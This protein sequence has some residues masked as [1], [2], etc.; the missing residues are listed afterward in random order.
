MLRHPRLA[1]AN[2]HDQDDGATTGEPVLL[3]SDDGL[4]LVGAEH[5]GMV[6][7]RRDDV[8]A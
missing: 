7:R 5:R 2:G 6:A 1:A 4:L 8:K 3:D